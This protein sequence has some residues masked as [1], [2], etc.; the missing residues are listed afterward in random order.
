MVGLQLPTLEQAVSDQRAMLYA[1]TLGCSSDPLDP[2]E[3]RYTF[4]TGL[5]VFPTMPVVLCNPGPWTADPVYQVT[6]SKLVYASESLKIHRPIPLD[7]PI[8]GHSRV[9]GLVDKGA[10]KGALILFERMLEDKF[11]GTLLATIESV[12]FC[13]ADGGFGGT[14]EG[15]PRFRKAPSR[16]PDVSVEV[17]TRPDA[18]LLY[19]LNGD[20]NP[21]HANPAYA[22]SAGFDRPI[23]HG[24][25]SFGMS[26]LA[27]VRSFGQDGELAS[28]EARFSRPVTPGDVIR[29]DFWRE[30]TGIAFQALV[31]ARNLLVLDG[32]YAEFVQGN[33]R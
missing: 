33:G 22:A 24:L 18:A 6:R 15:A 5:E 11:S 2:A 12:Y 29:F 32:G 28:I 4:E 7:T 9:K 8:I 21:L 30:P 19:R 31:N 27:L 26:G 13:R 25:C 3:L 20:R 14:C 10:D 23:L 16:A 17:P 1:L